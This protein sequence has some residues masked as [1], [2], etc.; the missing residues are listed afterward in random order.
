MV[1]VNAV[2][3]HATAFPPHTTSDVAGGQWAPASVQ[4]N[5]QT[6]AQFERILTKAYQVHQSKGAAY[7]VSPRPNYATL[8]LSGRQPW[9]CSSRPP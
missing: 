2:A 9:D 1:L 8:A 5:N 3:R 7:G 6:K 4:H